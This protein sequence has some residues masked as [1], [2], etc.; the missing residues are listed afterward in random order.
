VDQQSEFHD[1][2][3]ERFEKKLRL[4]L[5]AQPEWVHILALPRSARK[6]YVQRL[7]KAVVF[8]PPYVTA[9]PE[10][11]KRLNIVT[12]EGGKPPSPT[13]SGQALGSTPSDVA[14]T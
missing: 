13:G 9:P 14:T 8:I 7:V 6:A 11:P 12:S 5:I 1:E 2:L 10:E 3:A 4:W